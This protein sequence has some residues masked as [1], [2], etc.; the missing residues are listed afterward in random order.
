MILKELKNIILEDLI[1]ASKTM[2]SRHLEEN[3]IFK[4]KI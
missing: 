3:K 1:G 2:F 4:T